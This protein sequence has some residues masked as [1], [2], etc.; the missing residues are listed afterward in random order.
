V[1]L[2][3]WKTQSLREFAGVA[4][5][6]PARVASG[7]VP[8]HDDF[9]RKAVAVIVVL[10]VGIA[11]VWGG[12]RL[13]IPSRFWLSPIESVSV[14]DRELRVVRVGYAQGLRE[15]GSWIRSGAQLNR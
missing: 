1:W 11:L 10:A 3:R 4:D 13:G 6:A 7:I 8:P 15:V 9:M 14:D 2:T 5:G 12:P